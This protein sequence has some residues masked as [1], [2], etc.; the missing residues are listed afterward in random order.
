MGGV[1]TDLAPSG[2]QIYGLPY[3]ARS[4]PGL[5]ADSVEKLFF[6]LVKNGGVNVNGVRRTATQVVAEGLPIPDSVREGAA[7][8]E[9]DLLAQVRA[10][11]GQNQ[12]IVLSGYS[13]GSWVIRVALDALKRDHPDD[14]PAIRDS[15]SGIGLIADPNN[16]LARPSIPSELDQGKTYRV[17]LTGDAVCG[18]P[19][20]TP[21]GNVNCLIVLD[22]FCPHVRY[23]TE[24]TGP[25][26]V[27][28]AVQEVSLFLQLSLRNLSTRIPSAVGVPSNPLQ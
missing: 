4:V 5:A 15:I 7:N 10:C 1:Y 16:A 17:C 19:F 27:G 2:V 9:A 25:A 14:W 11:H 28:T 24:S 8:L 22:P 20:T 23:G 3:P 18:D 13:Q 6:D 21:I 12:K 26:T